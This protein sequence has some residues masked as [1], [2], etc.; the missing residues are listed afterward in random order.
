MGIMPT[1]TLAIEGL[2]SRIRDA[3]VEARS[4][5]FGPGQVCAWAQL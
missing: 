5:V 2:E 3:A 4:Q 1:M